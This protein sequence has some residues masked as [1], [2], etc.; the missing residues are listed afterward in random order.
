MDRVSHDESI[1][2]HETRGVLGVLSDAACPTIGNV[3]EEHM[4]SMPLV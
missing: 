2:S 3:Q 1:L 4:D